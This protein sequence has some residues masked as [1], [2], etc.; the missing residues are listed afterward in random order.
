MKFFY[1]RDL[2]LLMKKKSIK[3]LKFRMSWEK[4]IKCKKLIM[5][6]VDYHIWEIMMLKKLILLKF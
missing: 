4:K 1:E 2:V 3:S 5:T 6:L